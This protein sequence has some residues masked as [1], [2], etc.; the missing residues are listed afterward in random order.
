MAK[1]L[2][3]VPLVFVAAAAALPSASAWAAQNPSEFSQSEIARARKNPGQFTLDESSIKIEKI[4]AGVPAAIKI[5][6]P[7]VHPSGVIPDLS[8]IIN[9][10]LKIWDIIQKNKPVVDITTQYASAL[11]K[12]LSQW[13]DLAEWHAPSGDVYRLTA[14]NLYGTRVVDVTY[15]VLR[16]YGGSDNGVGRY[17]TE[18]T[19]EPLKVN[20]DWGY[21]LS[22]AVNIPDSGI[23]N[24][25][26]AQNPVAGMTLE[27][28]WRIDTAL[29]TSAG[30]AVYYLQGDGVLRGLGS[31][32]RSK[33]LRQG[34]KAAASLR[35]ASF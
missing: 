28:S 26:T 16:S 34:A 23:I 29:K 33:L 22:L 10:G 3:L 7:Q 21:K 24:V 32:S 1:Y 35:R 4:A 9:L 14:K 5:P 2:K 19:V 13:T 18:V 8:D 17:L 25:G 31:F 15:E 12:N 11:P 27:T 30:R 6:A 20:V